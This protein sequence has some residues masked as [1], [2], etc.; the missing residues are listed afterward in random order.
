MAV[1]APMPRDAPV[2]IAV[3]PSHRIRLLP[4]SAIASPR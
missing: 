3:T 4:A 2:M 1:A